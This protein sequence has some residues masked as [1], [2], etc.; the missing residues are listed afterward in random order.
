[1]NILIVGGASASSV[2]ISADVAGQFIGIDINS[3]PVSTYVNFHTG[4]GC[5]D[6]GALSYIDFGDGSGYQQISGSPG[7]TY[8]KAGTFTARYKKCCSGQCQ[9]ASMTV[10]VG[11]GAATVTTGVTVAVTQPPTT[12]TPYPVTVPVTSA[13]GGTS[14]FNNGNIYTVYNGPTSPTFVTF[15]TPVQIISI[16]NYHWNNGKGASPGSIA[17]KHSDG[18]IHGYWSASG[19]PGQGGV[20]NANWIANPSVTIKAGTYTV[21]DSDPSTWAQNTQSGNAGMTRIVYLPVST[22]SVTT[23]T[24]QV[25]A[26]VTTVT[27]Q[28]TTQTP[29]PGKGPDLIVTSVEGQITALPGEKITVTDTVRNQGDAEMKD[30]YTYYYLSTNNQESRSGTMLPG[31]QHTVS[32]LSAGADDTG[33]VTVT[34][35]AD[36]KPG[37]YYLRVNVYAKPQVS[38][39]EDSNPWN[40]Y[41]YAASSIKVAESGTGQP[42]SESQIPVTGSGQQITPPVSQRPPGKYSSL[43]ALAALQM[44]VGKRISDTSYDLISDGKIDSKDAREILRLAVNQ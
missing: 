29:E 40:N 38:L 18:T 33:S 37:I 3:I 31:E 15:T 34:I 2:S 4:G 9:E 23:I 17:L 14:E 6:I 11:T 25:S 22:S 8:I 21:L 10:K 16:T 5:T 19:Q 27:S 30:V 26:P 39:K 28:V 13:Q 32:V 43:D 44:S 12:V 42:A 20:Q 7:H 24:P 36:I 35:P 1:M 41:L